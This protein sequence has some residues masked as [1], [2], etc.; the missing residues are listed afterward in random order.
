MNIDTY[1]PYIQAVLRILCVCVFFFLLLVRSP[2]TY[3]SVTVTSTGLKLTADSADFGRPFN[4]GL[5]YMAR[6]Q[7]FPSDPHLCAKS[8]RRALND[9]YLPLPKMTNENYPSFIRNVFDDDLRKNIINNR[10]EDEDRIVVPNDGSPVAILALRGKCTYEEKA[11]AAARLLPEGVVHFVVVYDNIQEDHLIKMAGDGK[12]DNSILENIG[13]TFVSQESGLQLKRFVDWQP[14][15]TRKN[16][17]PHILLSSHSRFFLSFQTT[18]AKWAAILCLSFVCAA[19]CLCI[20]GSENTPSDAQVVVNEGTNPG[21]YRHG[22]RLLNE[23]E[24]KELPEVEFGTA[25]LITRDLKKNSSNSK[26]KENTSDTKKSEK[27]DDKKK[28]ADTVSE[29]EIATDPESLIKSDMSQCS[30]NGDL[31]EG[32]K[33]TATVVGPPSLRGTTVE[34]YHSGSCSICIEDYEPGEMIRVLPCGHAFHSDCILPWLTDRS[35][36]CPLCKALFEVTR[37]GDVESPGDNEDDD[38]ASQHSLRTRTMMALGMNPPGMPPSPGEINNSN[39]TEQQQPTNSNPAPSRGRI[40]DRVLRFFG[41]Q[42]N[43]VATPTVANSSGATTET[44]Q[45][46]DLQQPLLGRNEI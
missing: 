18:F 37:E 4:Y 5:E 46:T 33:V 34:Y 9:S 8:E 23:D 17:G 29:E 11:L 32:A 43:A 1:Y 35:P 22:L 40:Q 41:R 31:Q 15:D 3:G 30:K 42:R 20:L 25:E 26:E 19:S 44:A 14:E 16:G 45:S 10:L 6:L 13:L 39:T 12:A 7:Y 36:T 28:E 27:K 2:S 38:N 21:R 24:V